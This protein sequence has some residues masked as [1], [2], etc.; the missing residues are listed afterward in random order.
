[1]I[2]V[3]KVVVTAHSKAVRKRPKAA[4]IKP[5]AACKCVFGQ[6]CLLKKAEFLPRYRRPESSR[7]F[8]APERNGYAA[9]MPAGSRRS[10]VGYFS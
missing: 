7:N 8:A 1:L 9:A 4:G 2:A 10:Q 3:E 5:L 6:T